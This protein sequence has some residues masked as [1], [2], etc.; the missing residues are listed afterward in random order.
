M[1]AS[2][3]LGRNATVATLVASAVTFGL[4]SSASA[5][6]VGY[7][8][9]LTSN[10]V[11]SDATA[12]TWTSTSVHLVWQTDGNLVLYCNDNGKVLWATNTYGQD[13]TH[14]EFSG[15]G[16]TISALEG[17]ASTLLWWAGGGN[18][19]DYA[20]VQNDGNFVIY[21]PNG[22]GA[23]WATGTENRC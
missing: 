13:D 1:K 19:N 22:G 11:W 3:R 4:A 7:Y 6:S 17:G 21:R 18:P 2:K 5:D 8:I 14:I 20:Y 23:E 9:G 10:I 12:H 15:G 16:I